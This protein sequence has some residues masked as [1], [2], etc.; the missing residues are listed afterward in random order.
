M[1]NKRSIGSFYERAAAAYLEKQGCR[2]LEWNYRCRYGE[3]DL[4]VRDGEYL[5]FVEV[6]YRAD[7]RKGSPFDAVDIRKQRILSK[8]ALCYLAERGW[9]DVPCRFDVVGILGQELSVVRN[10]FDYIAP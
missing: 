1:Q 2:I 4:I 9:E 6:K 3:V 7:D 5:V 8:C 10:A